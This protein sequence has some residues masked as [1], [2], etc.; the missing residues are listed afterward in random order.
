[1]NGKRVK[2]INRV[3]AEV[4]KDNDLPDVAY[5]QQAE[6]DKNNPN[7]TTRLNYSKRFVKQQLKKKYKREKQQAN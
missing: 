5:M 3:A 4:A 7:K 6:S 1:M 2:E